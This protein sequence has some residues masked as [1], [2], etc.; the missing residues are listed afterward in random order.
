[1]EKIIIKIPEI[2]QFTGKFAG[3]TPVKHFAQVVIIQLRIQLPDKTVDFRIGIIRLI[4]FR[5][6]FFKDIKEDI[7]LPVVI[8]HF[9]LRQIPIAQ[10][11]QVH[12]GGDFYAGVFVE[13]HGGFL[14]MIKKDD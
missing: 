8:N 1:M 5:N 14:F 13:G 3:Q 6:A 11:R 10:A 12:K 4:D 7:R 2:D 9:R